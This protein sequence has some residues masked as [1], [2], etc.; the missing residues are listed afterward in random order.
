MVLDSSGW[1][2]LLAGSS[3]AHLFEPALHA[4][5]LVVP[6]IVRYEVGR[7]ALHH[8]GAVGRELALTALSK[9]EQLPI[10]DAVADTASEMAHAYKLGMA[11][12]LVYAVAQT[13]GAEI[14]TQDRDFERLPNVR[15]FP[16]K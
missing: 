11:D 5:P 7:Y 9:F 2:E 14:W 8:K 16:K 10:D 6:S 13:A 15:Y 4:K 1:I 12:A 3:R